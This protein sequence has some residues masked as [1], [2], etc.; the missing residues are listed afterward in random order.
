[1]THDFRTIVNN[2]SVFGT[3]SG[4]VNVKG[5]LTLNFLILA[6]ITAAEPA[7]KRGEL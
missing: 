7:G 2:S 3:R 4:A 6:T 5:L 1:M